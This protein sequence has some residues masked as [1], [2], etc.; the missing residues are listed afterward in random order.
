MGPVDTQH[1]EGKEKLLRFFTDAIKSYPTRVVAAGVRAGM[2]PFILTAK[3]LNPKFGKTYKV[4]VK[5][6]KRK[7]PMIIAGSFWTSGGKGNKKGRR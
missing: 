7:V 3:T 2:K 5:N 1:I 6:L 4:K